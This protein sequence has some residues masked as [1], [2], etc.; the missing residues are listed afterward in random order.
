M[1]DL[2]ALAADRRRHSGDCWKWNP[3]HSLTNFGCTCGADEDKED[4]LTVDEAAAFLRI[5]RNQLYDAI[6][7]LEIPHRR[8]GRTIRLSRN[9]LIQWLETR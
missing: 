7:R 9:A 3:P 4:V 1:T 6:G 5:G 2:E 8:I